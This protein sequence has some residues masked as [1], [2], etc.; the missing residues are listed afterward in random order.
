[1]LENNN[2]TLKNTLLLLFTLLFSAASFAGLDYG[3]YWFDSNN[4]SAKGVSSSGTKLSVSTSF[5]DSSK[6]TVIYFHGWQKDNGKDTSKRETFY[7]DRTGQKTLQSWKSA[8]WNVGIFYWN[9]FAD[10]PE[11]KDAE[12]KL[13]SINGPKGMRYRD[14]NGAYYVNTSINKDI[15]T[16]AYEH[17]KVALAGNSSQ[18]VRF[19]GHSL[20]NQLATRVAKLLSDNASAGG[21]SVG[22]V[23]KRLELLDPFWSKDGK[24]FLGGK[25]TG[26][27]CREYVSN[28]K[29]V[30]GIKVTRYDSSPIND[31]WI[32][33]HNT[34]MNSMVARQDLRFWYIGSVTN[35]TPGVISAKHVEARH[36]YFASHGTAAPEEV[37]IN[38]LNQ[39]KTTGKVAASAATSDTRIGEMM[40]ANYHWDQVEG[41]QTTDPADDQFERKDG[42]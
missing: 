29:S 40:S 37:T 19:A 20:G 18:H 25:W 13:W 1:M 6:K 41:R 3:L 4:N 22:T 32:G 5:Y 12:A 16:I 9:Q 30:R 42:K 21:T 35:V 15:G 10:E 24:S 11:V 23:P 38:W 17:I 33:D 2:K 26:E 14:P 31:L 28:L 8:G 34:P 7:W 27:V 39:R 36:W